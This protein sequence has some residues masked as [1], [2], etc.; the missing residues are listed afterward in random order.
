MPGRLSR[1]LIAALLLSS[2]PL[3]AGL[4]K[5][6]V[7]SDEPARLRA[8]SS[9]IDP[10]WI[11]SEPSLSPE[12]EPSATRLS[13]QEP[14]RFWAWDFERQRYY[15]LEAQ[16]LHVSP[17]L[18]VYVERGQSIPGPA[19]L[20]L[21]SFF[22]DRAL[23]TL[24]AQ[25][26][27][28]A[29]PGIDDEAAITLLLM[30][31]RDA[32]YYG[33]PTSR[34]VTGY[35]DPANQQS[36]AALDLA[37][38][39]RRSNAREMFYIDIAHP[40]NSGGDEVLRAVAHEL[41]HLILWNLDPNEEAWLEEGI[42]ELAGFLCG[43]GHPRDAVNLYL[44]QPERPIVGWQGEPEDLGKVYLFSL[45]L[46]DRYTVEHPDWLGRLAASTE[47]GL[48]G[49]EASIPDGLSAAAL[50]RD[51]G[52]ALH[53][54]GAA[55]RE[56]PFGFR[57]I[58]LGSSLPPDGFRAPAVRYHAAGRPVESTFELAAWQ[59]RAE[60]F[61]MPDR[62]VSF[63]FGLPAGSCMAS[64]VLPER[65]PGTPVVE[66]RCTEEASE[67]RSLLPAPLPEEGRSDLLVLLVGPGSTEDRAW[68]R[69]EPNAGPWSALLPLVNRR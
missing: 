7:R 20:R 63:E 16:R 8:R 23:P 45:Y 49:L 46:Y 59:P 32:K 22:E 4:T 13:D 53:L 40:T 61:G 2:P 11:G 17:K 54:A 60:R 67:G 50:F 64:A 52:I 36:Q 24:H 43:L 15:E 66:V 29:S 10:D 1:A 44:Q 30:D 57:S 28:E 68:L 5:A 47:H 55:G 58:T 9:T 42:A 34:F 33:L 39:D 51:F 65:G 35:F 18:W 27:E 19:L 3:L 41:T 56:P 26:G 31:L 12:A 62:Q 6:G 69:F 38:L 21:V 25:L 14:T 48:A 37:G